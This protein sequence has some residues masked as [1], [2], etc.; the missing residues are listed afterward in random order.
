MAHMF[1]DRISTETKSD[2]E[3]RLFEAFRDQLDADYIVFHHVNWHGRDDEGRP[4][5]GEADFVIAHPARGI[6]VVEVKGGAIR[7]NRGSQTWWSTGRNGAR[8]QLKRSP[9]EQAVE[10]QHRLLEELRQM[11]GLENVRLIGGHAVAFP[12][13]H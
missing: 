5:D 8:H 11:R 3:R 9:I 13:I 10:S 2:A 6:L 4:R 12:D 7:Y 1:P